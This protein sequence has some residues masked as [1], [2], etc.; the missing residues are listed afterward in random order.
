MKLVI[1]STDFSTIGTALYYTNS[2]FLPGWNYS[3]TYPENYVYGG[4]LDMPNDLGSPRDWEGTYFGIDEDRYYAFPSPELFA[5]SISLNREDYK[6]SDVYYHGSKDKILGRDF[7]EYDFSFLVDKYKFNDH[8]KIQLLDTESKN[9]IGYKVEELSK[10]ENIMFPSSYAGEPGSLRNYFGTTVIGTYTLFLLPVPPGVRKVEF[11]EGTVLDLEEIGYN[12]DYRNLE[13][14]DAEIQKPALSVYLGPDYMWSACEAS[15]YMTD[16]ALWDNG[17]RYLPASKKYLRGMDEIYS[18]KV[19]WMV[20]T[21]SGQLLDINL[22]YHSWATDKINPERNK[23]K[24]SLRNDEFWSTK[25]SM[26]LVKDKSGILLDGRSNTI[27]ST[28]KVENH[29]ILSRKMRKFDLLYYNPEKAYVQGDKVRY[30]GKLW[31]ANQSVPINEEPQE[32]SDY[33]DVIEQVYSPFCSYRLGERVLFN[34][35]LWESLCDLNLGNRPDI[36]RQWILSSSTSDFFTSRA[37][38]IVNPS[39]AGRIIPGGQVRIDESLSERVFSVYESLGY[40]LESADRVCSNETGEYLGNINIT[41]ENVNVEGGTM[42][43]KAV[44]VSS[45]SWPAIIESGKLI[46][47]F[48]SVPTVITIQGVYLGN[49]YQYSSWLFN[50]ERIQLIREPSG[51]VSNTIS[52]QPGTSLVLYPRTTLVNNKFSRVISTYRDRY[53]VTR[54]KQLSLDG[55]RVEDFIDFSSATYTF[56]IDKNEMIIDCTIGLSEF[57]M[58]DN[59]IEVPYGETGYFKFYQRDT[60]VGSDIVVTLNDIDTITIP[61]SQVPIYSRPGTPRAIPGVCSNYVL[62]VMSG[63]YEL[64]IDNQIS[65]VNIKIRYDN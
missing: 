18:E 46:F 26:P 37:N 54:T 63:Y 21:D 52:I 61:A 58:E 32:G 4:S 16:P 23:W 20:I 1:C 11:Y 48:K 34:G 56:Y 10:L 50:T 53:G 14:P 13:T 57:E 22:S 31:K 2:R 19:L 60:S 42:D 36:S 51:A 3:N 5:S 15:M 7:A 55:N 24:Y 49:T 29:P 47:N 28:E 65:D 39:G 59:R 27:L 25:D 33:W 62:S 43:K 17:F 12:Y 6:Y 9:M 44:I 45:D 30:L 40:E 64:R 41:T 38:I 35:A 8:L